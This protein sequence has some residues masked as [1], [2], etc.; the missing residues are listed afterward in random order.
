MAQY[1]PYNG[2]TPDALNCGR[3]TLDYDYYLHISALLYV[4]LYHQVAG[5]HKYFFFDPKNRL[6]DSVALLWVL[7]FMA[8]EAV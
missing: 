5:P 7:Y 1:V 2:G 3:N 8:V 6:V 4:S